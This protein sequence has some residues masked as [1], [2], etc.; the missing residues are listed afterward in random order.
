MHE[1]IN[2]NCSKKNI[3]VISV[4]PFSVSVQMFGTV[5]PLKLTLTLS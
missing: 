1:V 4:R 5:N 3:I 2:I